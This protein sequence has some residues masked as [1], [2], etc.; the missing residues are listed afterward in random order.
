ME[1]SP[2]S[3]TIAGLWL[4]ILFHFCD[5]HSLK[6][7]GVRKTETQYN[8]IKNLGKFTLFELWVGNVSATN[9]FQFMINNISH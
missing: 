6:N 2:D 7:N 4:P 9:V 5:Q 1:E 3:F 8:C